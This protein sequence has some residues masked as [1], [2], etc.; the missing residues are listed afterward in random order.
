MDIG[1]RFRQQRRK[2]LICS[3]VVALGRDRWRWREQQAAGSR[4][5]SSTDQPAPGS[6]LWG[7][8]L[9]FQPHGHFLT[10]HNA[11]IQSQ[12]Y[13]RRPAKADLEINMA[14]NPKQLLKTDMESH[15]QYL[16][17]YTDVHMMQ[18]PE[19]VLPTTLPSLYQATSAKSIYRASTSTV[20]AR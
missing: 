20:H 19:P 14:A 13:R 6:S 3:C 8:R 5:R 7:R 12:G 16:H 17:I 4:S 10:S 11:E 9:A 18:L 15:T 2:I 1:S